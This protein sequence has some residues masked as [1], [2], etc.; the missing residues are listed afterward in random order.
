MSDRF[1]RLILAFTTAFCLATSFG[2][3]SGANAAETRRI[4]TTQDAD[5]FGFDLRTEKNVSL[6]QCK[7]V[8]LGDNSCLAFTYNPK[9]KWC[10]LKADFNKL[11]ESVGSIAGKVV[12]EAKAAKGK[13]L[14]AAPAISFFAT[15]LV[16]EARRL[17]REIGGLE[18]SDSLRDLRNEAGAAG[19]N[20]DPRTAMEKFRLAAS[21]S[22]DESEI[23]AGYA[24]SALATEPSNGQERSKFQRDATSASWFAY[25][26]SR[27]KDERLLGAGTLK[28][29]CTAPGS[30][31]L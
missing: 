26:T 9:V 6:E 22:P 25:Q 20:G 3:S 27:T 17:K 19:M 10:F 23:W 2:S 29:L 13:D 12:T 28:A 18:S 16:D 8:C 21:M 1:N 5:Y 24:L 15:N 4:E 14:G 7:S 31:G 30:A 11:N